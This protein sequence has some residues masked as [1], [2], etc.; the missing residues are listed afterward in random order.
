[1]ARGFEKGSWRSMR[2]VFELHF[3]S[4][5]VEFE[6]VVDSREKRARVRVHV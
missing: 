2:T 5:K 6:D 4:L 1:M 3:E